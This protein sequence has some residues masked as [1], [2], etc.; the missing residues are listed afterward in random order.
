[1]RGR[2]SAVQLAL[3][4]GTMLFV[5]WLA[6]LIWIS[7]IGPGSVSADYAALGD[8]TTLAALCAGVAAF[9][10]NFEPYREW[11]SNQARR[12]LMSVSLSVRKG[13]FPAEPFANHETM[14]GGLDVNLEV[15]IRNHGDASLR[16]G[17]VYIAVMASCDIHPLELKSGE[18]HRDHQLIKGVFG[19]DLFPEWAWKS[20]MG[21][22]FTLIERDFA[23]ATFIYSVAIR[24][25]SPG[26]WPVFVTVNGEPSP[27]VS[28]LSHIRTGEPR[29]ISPT[30]K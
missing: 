6:V 26:R 15:V 11:K 28:T 20:E 25:P 13:E 8:I 22:R 18:E 23:P 12:P 30:A 29:S 5:T 16:D 7:T 17:L 21:L 4:A 14:V 1:M 27:N 10:I 19:D 24:T 3:L 9:I 2:F